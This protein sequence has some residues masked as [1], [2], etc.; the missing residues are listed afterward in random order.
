[1]PGPAGA[2]RRVRELQRFDAPEPLRRQIG[3]TPVKPAP[4]APT[5]DLLQNANVATLRRRRALFAAAMLAAVALVILLAWLDLRRE[6]ARAL[7]DF[8]AE[9]ATLAR[10]AA[11]ILAVRFAAAPG[12]TVDDVAAS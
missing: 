12:L 3:P 1:M 11:A 6:Q 8:S 7:A 4:F 5:D 2:M 10:A 9:Q